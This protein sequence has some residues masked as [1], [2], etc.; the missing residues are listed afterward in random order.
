VCLRRAFGQGAVLPH[1]EW[2]N[3]NDSTVSNVSHDDETAVVPF[4]VEEV[5]APVERELL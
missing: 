1:P 3:C 5:K 4:A 2:Q